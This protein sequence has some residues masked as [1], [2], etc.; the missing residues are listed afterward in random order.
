MFTFYSIAKCKTGQSVSSVAE[1]DKLLVPTL[2]PK[3]VLKKNAAVG[4]VQK[5]RRPAPQ[6]KSVQLT[7]RRLPVFLDRQPTS[8]S[9]FLPYNM[10]I[11]GSPTKFSLVS[12]GGLV[13]TTAHL[14]ILMAAFKPRF[15]NSIRFL[16]LIVH[17]NARSP[18]T[19]APFP[20]APRSALRTLLYP[21]D[22]ADTFPSTPSG[23][24]TPVHGVYTMF[25][26]HLQVS[27][28]NAMRTLC[29]FLSFEL[30]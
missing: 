15:T 20:F 25:G 19:F 16:P 4:G 7:C 8:G 21:Q 26:T 10:T 5:W 1:H 28:R 22:S 17:T 11:R 9:S 13:S 29:T 14:L 3:A 2:T 12:F 27:C 18:R 24:Y 6:T 30:A 23:V